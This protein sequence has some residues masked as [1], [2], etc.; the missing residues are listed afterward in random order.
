MHTAS[1]M[2]QPHCPQVSLHVA[3]PLLWQVY[4]KTDTH[5]CNAGSRTVPVPLHV[6]QWC[7]PHTAATASNSSSCSV[8]ND[9]EGAADGGGGK[10]W[11]EWRLGEHSPGWLPAHPRGAEQIN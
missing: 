4:T 10:A 3:H 2:K 7:C 1:S 9:C 5:D 6:C 11:G 8:P